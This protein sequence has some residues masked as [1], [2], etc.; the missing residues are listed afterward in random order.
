[1][2]FNVAH[3]DSM[4]WKM[5]YSSRSPSSSSSP[6]AATF[7]ASSSAAACSSSSRSAVS[8]AEMYGLSRMV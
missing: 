4:S 2:G 7:A 8:V 1:M 5:C 3:T 6:S